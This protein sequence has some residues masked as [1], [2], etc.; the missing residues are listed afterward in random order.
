MNHRLKEN[1]DAQSAASEFHPTSPVELGRRISA[2]IDLFDTRIKAAQVAER[3]T[4]MLGKYEKGAS[5]PPFMPLAR[6][7]LATNTRMEWLATGAGEML[8]IGDQRVAES[9][10]VDDAQT[11]PD[12][13]SQAVQREALTMA[14]QLAAEALGDKVL[15]PAK[16]A[17]LVSIIYDCLVEGLPEAKVLRIARVAAV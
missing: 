13:A 11:A 6:M 4:D 17:E 16:H 1:V 5:E 12:G 3:S 15:P 8:S 10:G 2:V 7:C 14:L 9:R